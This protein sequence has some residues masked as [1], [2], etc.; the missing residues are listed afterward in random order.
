MDKGILE[1]FFVVGF[2][3]LYAIIPLYLAVAAYK[4]GKSSF[5][6]GLTGLLLSIGAAIL[7]VVF[8][9]VTEFGGTLVGRFGPLTILFVIGLSI[10]A[11]IG[12]QISSRVLRSGVET[13]GDSRIA[14]N[15]W[16]EG[17]PGPVLLQL[18]V[19]ILGLALAMTWL[20]GRLV[21]LPGEVGG[22]PYPISVLG[23]LGCGSY[24]LTNCSSL[25]DRLQ[26]DLTKRSLLARLFPPAI[27]LVI[28]GCVS[29]GWWWSLQRFDA[30][31]PKMSVPDQY[32][33]GVPIRPTSIL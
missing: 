1:A 25:V 27:L 18:T 29:A 32:T 8:V 26:S 24:V 17:V 9:N 31:E 13:V 11:L 4:C 28:V 10:A 3:I 2:G 30:D 20:L 14:V 7:C 5:I 19:A 22:V 16:A 23:I 12:S 21:P 15:I 33:L 6:W